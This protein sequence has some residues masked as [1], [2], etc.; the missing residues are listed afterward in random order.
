ML[1]GFTTKAVLFA[2]CATAYALG[3]VASSWAQGVP[4]SGVTP[5]PSP[6]PEYA[7]KG[8]PLGAF[9]LF[10]TLELAFDSDDN[11][12]RLNNGQKGDTVFEITPRLALQSQWSRHYLALR[13]GA[14]AYEYNKY[15]SESRIDW[16]ADAE[17]RIDVSQGTAIFGGASYRH[18]F[19]PRSSPDQLNIAL[20]PTPFNVAHADARVQVMPNRF[21]VIAGVNYDKYQYDPTKV[22]VASEV[23]NKD[24]DYQEWDF[25]TRVM[26]EFSPGY[27]AFAHVAYNERNFDI[28][29]DR[30][31]VDR[32][33]NGYRA[34]VGV[35]MELTRLLTG[36]FYAGYLEQTY[37]APLGRDS[38]FNYGAELTWLPSPLV[39]VRVSAS[40][41]INE[42]VVSS[43]DGVA[44]DSNEQRFALGI[45]YSFRRNIIL[46]GDVAYLHD[47]FTGSGREDDIGLASIGATYL[48]NNYMNQLQICV[49]ESRLQHSFPGL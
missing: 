37:K 36:E 11:V 47:T 30:N 10:P 35:Q 20:E 24:R 28:H 7:P 33:S 42:T 38:G 40:H 26:Y 8:L 29:P 6:V 41:L 25:F 23:S 32:D 4:Q 13:G 22:P 21:G 3:A 18:T 1:K 31:G 16:D 14:T 43:I 2:T 34:N 46:H 27:S 5:T 19:E 48:M 44:T 45:D 39:A 15:D 49:P 9:R 12:F 17:G